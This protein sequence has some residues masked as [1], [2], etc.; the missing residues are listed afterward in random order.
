M[1]AQF[2]T[3][4]KFAQIVATVR[5]V[6]AGQAEVEERAPVCGMKRENAIAYAREAYGDDAGIEND[7]TRE[8]EAV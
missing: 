8:L 7:D 4:I 3:P 2:Y 6:V 5:G 1:A